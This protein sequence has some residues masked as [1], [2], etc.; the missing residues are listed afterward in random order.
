[1]KSFLSDRPSAGLSSLR[2]TGNRVFV[3]LRPEPEPPPAPAAEKCAASAKAK[4]ECVREDGRVTR[5]LVTCAC[6]EK[7]E[8]DCVYEQEESA[9][10]Q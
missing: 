3:P 5:I 9:S 4:V 7:V 1:M 8:I 2:T 10:P 6:G